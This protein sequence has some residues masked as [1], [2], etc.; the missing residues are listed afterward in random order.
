MLATRLQHCCAASPPP[1]DYHLGWGF[2]VP[3]GMPT[4]EVLVTEALG[5]GL[6]VPEVYQVH[7][8]A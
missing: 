8:H 1:E 6:G 3:Q 2:P 4:K 5:V 7:V